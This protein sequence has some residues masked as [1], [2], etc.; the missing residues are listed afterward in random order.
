MRRQKCQKE[1]KIKHQNKRLLKGQNF[2]LLKLIIFRKINFTKNNLRKKIIAEE[3]NQ[4]KNLNMVFYKLG[5][6]SKSG[7]VDEIDKD[8][9][10]CITLEDF[11][12]FN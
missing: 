12:K 3:E 4:T 5:F 11:Y 1:L 8:K 7:F 6:I 9:Y 10:N 2:A